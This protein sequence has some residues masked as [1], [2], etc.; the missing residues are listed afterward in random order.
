[1]PHLR[2]RYLEN[3]IRKALRFSPIVGILGQ[4]QTGKTTLL[5]SLV[6]SSYASLDDFEV[7][8]GA[9][10]NPKAF[11]A[12]RAI[13]FGVDECQLAPP[14]FPALKLHVQENRRP[15]QFLLTGSVRFTSR[16]AIRESLTGRIFNLELL[17]LTITEAKGLPLNDIFAWIRQPVGKIEAMVRVRRAAISERELSE[18]TARG[19]LPGIAFVRD[20]AIRRAKLGAHLET[21]LERDIRLL[22]PTTLPTARLRL[23]LVAL[24][25]NQGL[26]ISASDLSRQVRVS[27]PTLKR[28][29]SA[30]ESL[31]LIRRVLPMGDRKR[32]TYYLEDQ[33]MADFLADPPGNH[34]NI[35][36]IAFSQLFSQLR[37]HYPAD[38]HCFAYESRGGAR[39]PI[40][41]RAAGRE[42]GVIPV[43]GEAA[44]RSAQLSAESFLR[45]RPG[46]FVAILTKG[47]TVSRL[48]K[49]IIAMP[50]VGAI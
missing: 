30:F 40:V 41:L 39:V 4:R 28:L 5:R 15:G 33:G 29:L 19:G 27:A 10:L 23:L 43:P 16:K 48:K 6:G 9:E 12:D 24:A 35:L 37:Y 20:A 13:P 42:I 22:F 11:L 25:Q 47:T 17:P 38:G 2:H 8:Q 46:A 7:L 26:P 49:N 44:D 32:D 3:A 18:F 45:R 36:R 14:L 50:L 1:M 34:Q 21:L 31:F